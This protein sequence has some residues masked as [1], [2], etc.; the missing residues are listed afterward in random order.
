[1]PAAQSLP[2]RMLQAED[3]RPTGDVHS[4]TVR[5]S[6]LGQ[7]GRVRNGVFFEY[8]QEARI[9]YL[10]N[11]HTRGEK[12]SQHVIART[13]VDYR[14]AIGHRVEPYVVH[15]WIGHL[16]SRSFTIRSEIRDGDVV[17]AGAS[18]V[19]VCFDLET[20][21]TAEMAQHQRTRLEQELR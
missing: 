12:W 6:D 5:R 13:D 16:G 7:D 8:V 1:M 10:M 15:S 18:V 21:R 14:E 20:Q 17:V 4:L 11:L 9:Q 2:E 19:L 3:A